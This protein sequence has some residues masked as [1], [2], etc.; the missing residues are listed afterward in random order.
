MYHKQSRIRPAFSLIEVLLVLALL[1]AIAGIATVSLTG[2]LR[3]ARVLNAMER[4]LVIDQFLRTQAIGHPATLSILRTGGRIEV[5]A[6]RLSGER[7]SQW[8]FDPR[9]DVQIKKLDAAGSG[10]ESQEVRRIAYVTGQ[11]TFD[12]L[13]RISERNLQVNV[14]IAGGTGEPT[15]E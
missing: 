8:E 15:Q 1:S 5:V 6:A 2:P 9:I 3:K 10:N 4:W 12:Y 7:I 13:V 11:G 14:R